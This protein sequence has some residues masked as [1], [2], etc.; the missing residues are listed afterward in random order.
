MQPGVVPKRLVGVV[1]CLIFLL[2]PDIAGAQTALTLNDCV[3][4]TLARNHALQAQRLD[5]AAKE[6][7]ARGAKGLAGPKVTFSASYQR[8][9]DPTGIIVAHSL[10]MPAVFDDRAEIWGFNLNQNIFD[11]GKTSALIKFSDDTAR[12]QNCETSSQELSLVGNVVKSF[13]RILQLNDNIKAQ[14]DTVNALESLAS[15][16]RDKLKLGRV[17]EVDSLQVEAQLLAEKEKLLRY[18]NDRDR[19]LSLL[20]TAMGA[21][22][23]RVIE[24]TGSLN[25]YDFTKPIAADLSRN[26]EIQKAT[27]RK[28]QSEDLFKSAKADSALQLGITGRY[29]MTTLHRGPQDE[30]WI[31]MLQANLPVFDGGVIAANI[32]QS[33]LQVGKSAES[34]AQTV[35]DAEANAYSAR[36]SADSAAARVDAGKAALDRA[37]EAYRIVEL[38]FRVGKASVTDLLFAQATLTNAQAAYYQA[39]FDRVSAVVDL[40]TVYGQKVY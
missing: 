13:Y 12:L 22:Q 4:L 14:Q 30:F 29:S 2:M 6:S 26:P 33:K 1:T 21:E 37:Q 28:E 15:D 8:Q 20:K 24:L 10:T 35:S 5:L 39:I 40:K 25:D 36:L 16:T 17:A 18:Q 19:Q 38:S 23:S 34:Y 7:L 3:Q 9:E 31:V 32:R 11:A 27:V